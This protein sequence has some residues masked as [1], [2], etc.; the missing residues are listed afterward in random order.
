MQFSSSLPFLLLILI[1]SLAMAASLASVWVEESVLAVGS[2]LWRSVF[3]L[4]SRLRAWIIK[5]KRSKFWV[6]ALFFVV[7]E[8]CEEVLV[9]L[10]HLWQVFFLL[11]RQFCFLLCQQ[12]HQR[13][14]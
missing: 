2:E 13:T 3:H 10:D 14:C 7:D 6:V 1:S 11:L 8:V 5:V 12:V 4:L 9:V